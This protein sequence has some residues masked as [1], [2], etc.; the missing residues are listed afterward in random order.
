MADPTETPAGVPGQVWGNDDDLQ[1]RAVTKEFSNGLVT[2]DQNDLVYGVLYRV[3]IYNV[4]GHAPFKGTF[5][6][7]VDASAAFVINRL[8]PAA[9]A[10]AF[11]STDLGVADST[12]KLTIVFNQPVNLDPLVNANNATA[13]LDL[14]LSINSPDANKNG[15]TNQLKAMGPRGT[16]LTIAD[17]TMTIQ[18]SPTSA[19]GKTDPGDPILSVTYGN[20]DQIVVRR[21]NG[22]QVDR[23]SLSALIGAHLAGG[24]GAADGGG[25]GGDVKA[26]T[27]IMNVPP[28]SP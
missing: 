7:G 21:P 5:T 11:M 14:G 18:W 20:L 4:A 15:Q 12:G 3:D 25:A 19:L 10:V 24:G 13:S 28:A 22:E 6:A 9:L 16:Q 17:T 26:V 8:A 27:V 1:F 23:A 2:F